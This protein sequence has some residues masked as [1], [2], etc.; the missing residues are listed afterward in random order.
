ML[1]NLLKRDRLLLWVRERKAFREP[2][3]VINEAVL[4][5]R[6]IYSS[7]PGII[8]HDLETDHGKGLTVRGKVGHEI[9]GIGVVIPLSHN[10]AILDDEDARVVRVRLPVAVGY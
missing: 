1:E 7:R 4:V 5:D 3:T 2:I 8:R 6:G 9:G 10:P